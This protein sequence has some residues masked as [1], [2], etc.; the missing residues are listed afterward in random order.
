MNE[1]PILFSDEMVRAILDGRKSQTRRVVKEP[2]SIS[3][4][5]AGGIASHAPMVLHEGSWF[6]PEEWSPFGKA[7]DRLWV[8]EAFSYTGF[9]N[10]VTNQVMYRA[11]GD[12]ADR[13]PIWRPSIFMPRWA[14]RITLEIVNVRME[15]VQMIS[16]KDARAEGMPIDYS[17]D[18]SFDHTK[19]GGY[20]ANFRRLWDSIN[21]KR[22]FGWDENPWVWVIDFKRVEE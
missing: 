10:T 7:G 14:S 16:Y 1:R 20:Q 11:D 6:K 8:R 15:R 12:Q 18:Y 5:M 13:S 2:V 3:Q 19:M 4:K 22:G 21:A 17:G 9:G